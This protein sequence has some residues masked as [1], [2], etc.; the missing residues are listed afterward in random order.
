MLILECNPTLLHPKL[1]RHTLGYSPQSP[2]VY[3]KLTCQENLDLF[4]SMYNLPTDVKVINRK[5]LL[6]LV[7]LEQDAHKRADALS[8][9]MKKRLDLACSLVHDP[10]ILV[11]DE[12]TS[13]LDPFLRKQ[14]WMLIKR[15]NQKGTTVIM[16]SH[17]LDEIEGL[18]DRIA[19][20]NNNKVEFLGNPREVKKKSKDVTL[21]IET[22]E[23]KYD[24][25]KKVLAKT[26]KNSRFYIGDSLE[27]TIK[28]VRNLGTVTQ[29]A[30]NAVKK[31]KQKV[32]HLSYSKT[33]ISEAF[34][35]VLEIKP[36]DS[37]DL[38]SFTG[39]MKEIKLS[40]WKL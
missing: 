20:I 24:A 4:G 11:L 6:R 18:C 28:N 13:D 36:E 19:I 33:G 3:D 16:S 14:M 37:E 27:I 10:K 29:K 35:K 2:S 12:P 8:G 30:F 1:L 23:A 31:A 38:N 17:F 22:E 25:L 5:I 7:G 15:I 9:G 26:F 32:L 34:E 40:K 21:K 39:K